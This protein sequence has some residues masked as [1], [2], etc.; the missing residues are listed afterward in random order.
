MEDETI[1]TGRC[2][3]TFHVVRIGPEAK[4]YRFSAVPHGFEI[5]HERCLTASRSCVAE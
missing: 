2:N 1:F 3:S 4:R 5:T